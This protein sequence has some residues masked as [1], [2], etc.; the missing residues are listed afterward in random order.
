MKKRY[1]IPDIIIEI[2]LGLLAL[3]CF[4]PFYQTVIQS[5]GETAGM[6]TKIQLIPHTFN[7]SAY[8]YLI[9]EGKAV[10]GL[11][12]SLFVTCTGTFVNMF[13]TSAGAYALSKKQLPGRN[14]ILN[15]IIFT[16]YFSGGLIPLFL[17]IQKLGLQNN[18]FV[19]ILPVA[20]N[21]FYLILMKNYF[22]AIP[23]SMEE[24]AKMDGA[25]DITILF[26]IILPISL[27]ILAAIALFYAVDRWNEW[28]FGM[29]FLNDTKLYP[30][31]LVLRE[32]ITNISMLFNNSSV[33]AEI[34]S[35]TQEI[36]PDSIKSAIIVISAVPIMIVYPSLQKY[37]SK[38]IM[39]GSIKG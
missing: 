10:R 3:V 28:W 38:G 39:M 21:T 30:L 25:N 36:Y 14:F 18:L 33:G 16:M 37:F 11:F 24:S 13:C 4:F 6:Q 31:Q 7:L 34:A 26:R 35:K 20:V 23:A 17:T 9:S 2:I 19:M 22:G 1:D 5:F 8:K 29:L 15:A 32:A 12:V 27:P